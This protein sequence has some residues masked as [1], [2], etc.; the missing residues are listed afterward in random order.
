MRF[1]VTLLTI[2]FTLL[3]ISAQRNAEEESICAPFLTSSSTSPLVRHLIR[4]ITVDE[5]AEFSCNLVLQD[6]QLPL[7]IRATVHEGLYHLAMRHIEQGYVMSSAKLEKTTLIPREVSAYYHAKQL[8]RIFTSSCQFQYNAGVWSM[9]ALVGKSDEAV[10]FFE[11]CFPSP[12]AE[13]AVNEEGEIAMEDKEERNKASRD[14]KFL[15]IPQNKYDLLHHL[16]RGHLQ[17]YN[18]EK[19]L[20]WARKLLDDFPFDLEM[21]FISNLVVSHVNEQRDGWESSSRLGTKLHRLVEDKIESEHFNRSSFYHRFKLPSSDIKAAVEQSESV[22]DNEGNMQN[23]SLFLSASWQPVVYKEVISNDLFLSHLQSRQPFVIRLNDS[24]LFDS[25]FGWDTQKWF[26][27]GK[28]YLKEKLRDSKVLMESIPFEK[29]SSSSSSLNMYGQGI[30]NQ[31][32]YQSFSDILNNNFNL[33]GKLYYLNIQPTGSGENGYA[34]PLHLLQTDLP[35]PSPSSTQDNPLNFIEKNLTSIN[36]WMGKVPKNLSFTQSRLH[37]DPTDNLYLLYEGK[38]RFH[39]W[40]PLAGKHLSPISPVYGVNE[41]GLPYHWNINSFTSYLQ[42]HL[43]LN[44]LTLFQLF[45]Q[46]DHSP[47]NIQSNENFEILENLINHDVDY[48]IDN[49]HFSSLQSKVKDELLLMQ[50][51][52]VTEKTLPHPEVIVD[53]EPGDILYLPSGY[54]HEVFSHSGFHSAIN[55]W[56]KPPQWKNAIATEKEISGRLYEK[57]LRSLLG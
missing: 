48:D 51:D 26:Y 52:H 29:T 55:I 43:K 20:Y 23:P 45:E 42:I 38:K 9:H 44:N 21:D 57:V 28:R 5:N 30:A 4:N 6:V 19:A 1:A 2:L 18:Y 40:N 39:L 22:V 32:E 16:V 49:I 31:R 27:N 8:A 25:Y 13:D 37:V 14:T 56:W 3:A 47:V 11:N 46:H 50:D 35:L 34:P 7:Q 15:S 17:L 41:D 54:Y 33:N 10:G 24:S 12:V 53:L 36:L